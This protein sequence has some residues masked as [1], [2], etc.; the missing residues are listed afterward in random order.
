MN[1]K[2]TMDDIS[3]AVVSSRLLAEIIQVS[4]R[5]IRQLADE[6]IIVRSSKGRYLLKESLKNYIVNLKVENAIKKN[7]KVEV[8]PNLDEV[9]DLNFEKACHEHVKRQIAELKLALM[10]GKVYEEHNVEEVLNDMLTAFKQKMLGVP[11]KLSSLLEN[12][13]RTVINQI[14]TDEMS[15]ILDEFSNYNPEDFL[16]DEFV[17]VEEDDMDE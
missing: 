3:T 15:A 6:G 4:D 7:D 10:K 12:R 1:S 9:R 5:R 2:D 13:D 8:N 14:L 11:A 17:D 16:S